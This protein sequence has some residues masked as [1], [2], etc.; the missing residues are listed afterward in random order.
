MALLSRVLQKWLDWV[1]ERPRTVLVL[2]FLAAV[3][4]IVLAVNKLEV[5]DDQLELISPN[6]PLISLS[7]RLD[8]FHLG[9]KTTFTVAV[10]APTPEQGMWFANALTSL[11]EQ[12]SKHFR[13]VLY[14]IDPNQLKSYALLYPDVEDIHALRAAVTDN[15]SILPGLAEEPDAIALLRLVNQEMTKRMVGELFTGFLDESATDTDTPGSKGP[16]DP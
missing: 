14:R 15:A 13:G 3:M 6:H 8:T 9:G 11:I 1:L 4:S 12:D 16:L 2:A 10:K 5:Q 7:H